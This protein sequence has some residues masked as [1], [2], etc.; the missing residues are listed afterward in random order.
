[1]DL[2]SADGPRLRTLGDLVA[3]E[4]KLAGVRPSDQF[5]LSAP[6]AQAEG[7]IARY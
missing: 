4:G 6:R 7:R 3:E 1:M 2:R 5:P